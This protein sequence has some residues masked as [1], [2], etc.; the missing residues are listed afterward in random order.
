MPGAGT[1]G[2]TGIG[3][4]DGGQA[5]CAPGVACT[6]GQSCTTSTG[7]ANNRERACFCDPNGLLA[8]ETCQAVDAG[9]DAGP[10]VNACSSG[11]TSGLTCDT[12]GTFCTATCSGGQTQTCFCTARGGRQDGGRQDG[13]TTSWTCLRVCTVP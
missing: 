5:I 6:D 2:A 1:G 9:M 11:V 4:S 3:G 12:Q 10:A 13:G 7:C 8:C